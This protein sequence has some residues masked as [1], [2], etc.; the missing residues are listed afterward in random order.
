MQPIVIAPDGIIRFKANAVVKWLLDQ[1]EQG[2]MV[3]MNDIARQ[4]FS[5]EDRSQFAQL[6]G[7]SVGG[8][9]ELSYVDDADAERA[10]EIAA[11]LAEGK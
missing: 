8:Y 1:A 9:N 5:D 6:I 7:Y 2:R 4:D 3:N 10:N 11:K